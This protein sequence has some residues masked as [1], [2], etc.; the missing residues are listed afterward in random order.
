MIHGVKITQLKQILDERGKVM[1]MLRRDSEVFKSFGE[2]YFST[3]YPNAIKGW[4]IHREMTLNYCVP[5]GNIKFVL[6][7]DREQS[8]TKGEVQEIFLG[9]DNYV[10]VTVPPM[11][12]NGFKGIGSEM[13]IVANC[14]SVPHDSNEIDRLDPF[15]KMIPYNWEIVHR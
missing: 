14:T 5:H 4:H 1:H 11:V 3:I 13:A 7:D 2:I 9:V 10:L 8:P 6:F 12:W 15:T